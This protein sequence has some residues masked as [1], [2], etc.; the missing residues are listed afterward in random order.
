MNTHQYLGS[1]FL[2]IVNPSIADF[3]LI[4]TPKQTDPDPVILENKQFF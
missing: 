1:F 3:L 2:I 4:N